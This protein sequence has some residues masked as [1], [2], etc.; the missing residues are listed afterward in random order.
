MDRGYSL[1]LLHSQPTSNFLKTV[2]ISFSKQKLK[3]NYE[4]NFVKDVD[5]LILHYIIRLFF[6]SKQQLD[7]KNLRNDKETTKSN[8]LLF[9]KV[10][11]VGSA[12]ELRLRTAKGKREN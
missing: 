2:N 6:L 8:F 3:Q 7:A 4:N 5:H 9:R 10:F 11:W 1:F 12:L